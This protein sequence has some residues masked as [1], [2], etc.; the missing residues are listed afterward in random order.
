M[1][2]FLLLFPFLIIA[3]LPG[4]RN[5][6]SAASEDARISV[7]VARPDV[8]DTTEVL[9]YSGTI[10]AVEEIP[11]SFSMPGTAAQVFVSEGESV[12]KGQLLATLNTASAQHSYDMTRAVE[13]RAEDGYRRLEPMVKNGT[14]PEIK[15]IEVQTGLDQARAATALA[16]KN[17]DDCRLYATT[18]GWVGKR[19][20]E[21]GA[22]VLPGIA[23]LTI[24]KINAVYARISIPEVD[25]PYTIS[26]HKASVSVGA[27]NGAT[28]Q[29]VIE[30]VGVMA[31]PLAHTYAVRIKVQNPARLLRPGMVCTVRME[32]ARTRTGLSLPSSA[33][34]EDAEGKPF[35]YVVDEQGQRAQ[36]RLVS[37]GRLQEGGMEILSGVTADDRVVVAGNHKLYPNAPVRIVRH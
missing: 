9:T 25:I 26:G 18:D 14:I 32:S 13:K 30:E 33:V 31:D 36:K 5:T 7:V 37:P 1:R 10:E 11:L 20:I 3:V 4:C 35:V 12:R 17:L 19:N 15:F 22:A 24:V 28:V 27:L 8:S 29:G 2:P 23:S 16:K 21:P 6:R 34:E